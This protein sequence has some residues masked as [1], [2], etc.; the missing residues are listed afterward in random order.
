MQAYHS[1]FENIQ[2]CAPLVAKLSG[3]CLRGV[4]L[5]RGCACLLRSNNPDNTAAGVEFQHKVSV[6]GQILEPWEWNDSDI[7][8]LG[9]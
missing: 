2:C 6:Y 1:Y 5:L 3:F 8:H 4:S 9:Y 7:C